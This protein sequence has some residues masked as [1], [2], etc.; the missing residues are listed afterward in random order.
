[1]SEVS[2][3]GFRDKN[4]KQVVLKDPTKADKVVGATAGNLAS[5]D[6]EGNLQDSGK[7]ISDFSLS[8]HT[9][10][11][12]A[13]VGHKH[14]SIQTNTTPQGEG[15]GDPGVAAINVQPYADG[16]QGCVNILLKK[17]GQQPKLLTIPYDALDYLSNLI[18][19]PQEPTAG[20]NRYPTSGQVH[21]ALQAREGG[22]S[23]DGAGVSV[24]TNEHEEPVIFFRIPDGS[25]PVEVI[26]NKDNLPY[27]GRSIKEP[28]APTFNSDR[29]ITSGQVFEAL[30]K[31]SSLK[32]ATTSPKASIKMIEET[33]G[34]DT[35]GKIELSLTNAAGVKKTAVITQGKFDQ[36]K[37]LVEEDQE[38]LYPVAMSEKLIQSQAVW[39]ALH[40]V[41]LHIIEDEDNNNSS[42]PI[43]QQTNAMIKQAM[44][45]PSNGFHFGMVS[46][47]SGSG[48]DY[49]YQG[50]IPCAF[51]WLKN[52]ATVEV[53]VCFANV[54]LFTSSS[55]TD[56][57]PLTAN[58]T[59][60]TRSQIGQNIFF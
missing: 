13:V 8:T 58:F 49:V 28:L 33:I 37:A 40:G 47:F 4:G 15:P 53:T 21:A 10:S 51:S 56:D 23:K 57:D 32:S 48:G 22:I 35:A 26:L 5:L 11:E 60:W 30:E 41:H 1:M 9:H 20:S 25:T 36:F 24:E 46:L 7:S 18:A 29:P 27:L 31:K 38:E 52:N 12:Y 54:K 59:T 2:R 42:F 50:T 55:I 39:R 14:N 16:L 6:E 44:A 17:Q 34:N 19:G 43:T 45:L 3:K